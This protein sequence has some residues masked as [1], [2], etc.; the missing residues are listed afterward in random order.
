MA[1]FPLLIIVV[2]IANAIILLGFGDL[3]GE[4]GSISLL[5]GA[6][7]RIDV[8]DLLVMGGLVLLYFE[9]L[10]STRS[11]TSSIVDHVLSMFLFVAALLEFL[12]LPGFANSTFFLIVLMTFIDVIAGFTVTISTARR[13]IGLDQGTRL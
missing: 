12:A 7:W 9:I 11:A 1:A 2:G 3:S 10:K 4:V 8:G 13:D 6:V 5:S